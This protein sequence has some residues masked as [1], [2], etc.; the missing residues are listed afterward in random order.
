MNVLMSMTV[1]ASSNISFFI[2]LAPRL[3]I[4]AVYKQLGEEMKVRLDV[5]YIIA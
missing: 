5:R 4:G 2:F 1:H 3:I